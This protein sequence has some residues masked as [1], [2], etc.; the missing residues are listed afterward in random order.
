[1]RPLVVFVC[2]LVVV[3]A[4]VAHAGPAVAPT[5]IGRANVAAAQ[6]GLYERHLYAWTV[7]GFC[8]QATK[9]ALRTFQTG[10]GLPPS[11]R[12]TGAT[13]LAL[14]TP[15]VNRPRIAFGAT[16]LPVAALQ[17]RLAW[18][19][20]PSGPPTTTLNSRVET[21]LVRFQGWLSLPA[22]GVLLRSPKV[23]W[24]C[25]YASVGLRKATRW[26]YAPR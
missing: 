16:G 6:A 2:S 22:D 13:L 17:F 12:L 24:T 10:A 11:G 14:D 4:A 21:A 8:G 1:M 25:E 18:H 15:R 23:G 26:P 7:D 20:F 19:G 3:S 5:A 9:A